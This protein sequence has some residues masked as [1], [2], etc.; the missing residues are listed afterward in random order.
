MATATATKT[1]TV[2]VIK[3]LADAEKLKQD[4]ET[5]DGA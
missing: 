4:A 2:T 1:F 5:P 3:Q